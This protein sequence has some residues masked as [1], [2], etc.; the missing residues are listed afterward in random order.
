MS[1]ESA[2]LFIDRMNTDE[3]FAKKVTQCKDKKARMSFVREAGFNF[4]PEMVKEAS[5]FSIP[6]GC[7]GIT[8][9]VGV[10]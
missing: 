6:K 1:L 5:L 2:K 10:A 9:D 8:V 7:C 4:T 3:D